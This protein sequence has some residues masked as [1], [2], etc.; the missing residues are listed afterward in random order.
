MS[1]SKE[2]CVYLVTCLFN[3][4]FY[5]GSTKNFAKRKAIHVSTLRSKKHHN[6]HM[7]AAWNKYGDHRFV[8]HL[9]EAV[10]DVAGLIEREQWWMDA[11]KAT[12]FGYNVMPN[13]RSSAGRKMS[14]EARAKMSQRKKGSPLSTEHRA[15]LSAA[16]VGRKLTP[17]HC[18]AIRRGLVGH[19]P[20]EK[21]RKAVSESNRRRSK[22]F[23][24]AWQAETEV[25]A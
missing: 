19:G 23:I 1:T 2:G 10:P 4:G 20:N 21:C 22:T 17:E 14:D 16:K 24:E 3:G 8:F 15:A 6:K 18:A 25:A 7:Q 5:V 12:S 13:A 9:L 11:M